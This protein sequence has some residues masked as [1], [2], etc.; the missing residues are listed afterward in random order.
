MGRHGEKLDILDRTGIKTVLDSKLKKE[1]AFDIVIE[2]TGSPGGLAAAVEIVKSC[3]TIVLKTTL[4]QPPE[5]D[6]NRLVIDEITLVGSRC[7]PFDKA[8]NALEKR[9][10]DTE[11]LVSD[12]FGLDEG[13]KAMRAASNKDNLKILLDMTK[14]VS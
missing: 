12:M 14:N 11:R 6:M 3:G 13:I 2:A 9:D 5:F 8:L 1:R 4:A 7:G 10:V